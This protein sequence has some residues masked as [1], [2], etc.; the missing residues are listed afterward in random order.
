MINFEELKIKESELLGK[1]QWNGLL[2]D[3]RRYFEGNVG[4]GVDAPIAK[5]SLGPSLSKI[6]L[7]LYQNEEGTS[8]YGMGVTAGHFY[9]N[10]GNPQ[11]KFAFLDRAGEGALEIFTILGNGN[12]GIGT[13]SPSAKLFVNGPL[14]CGD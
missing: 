12:V 6:K 10:I 9:L 5:L 4:L 8:Y 13:P 2:D 14:T 7:A 11:A 3:T 1:E